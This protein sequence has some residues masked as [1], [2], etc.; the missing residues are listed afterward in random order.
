LDEVALPWIL[1]P[2]LPNVNAKRSDN[3]NNIE[4]IT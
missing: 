4:Q 3:L 1:D 2:T